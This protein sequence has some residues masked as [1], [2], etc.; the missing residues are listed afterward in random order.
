MPKHESLIKTQQHRE[1]V[2]MDAYREEGKSETVICAA[3]KM[4]FEE[5]G[6]NFLDRCY[7]SS[8]LFLFY[9]QNWAKCPKKSTKSLDELCE[10]D[11]SKDTE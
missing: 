7:K 8:C 9:S 10:I 11:Y 1:I 2:F 5:I 4:N 3:R 6:R